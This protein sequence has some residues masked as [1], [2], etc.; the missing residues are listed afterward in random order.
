[1]NKQLIALL[2][3]SCLV[4]FGCGETEEMTIEKIKKP[5]N[6]QPSIDEINRQIWSSGTMTDKQA[7]ILS[8]RQYL[9]VNGLVS[10]TDEQAEILSKNRKVLEL[11]GLTSITDQQAESLGMVK[12]LFLNGLA[13]ITD[14]QAESVSNAEVLWLNGLTSITD[15]QAESLSKPVNLFISADLQPLIDKSK[16]E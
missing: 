8:E 9:A 16:N 7:M 3:S 15:A 2:M 5:V 4:V 12:Y 14:E 10:I 6:Q 1:M 13:S 11:N